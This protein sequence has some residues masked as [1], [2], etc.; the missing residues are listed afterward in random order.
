MIKS[1]LYP[2]AGNQNCAG[3][4]LHCILDSTRK[5]VRVDL[6]KEGWPVEASGGFLPGSYCEM[7]MIFTFL[8]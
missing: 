3:E 7:L 5:N 2:T 1:H 4:V 6:R 8:K